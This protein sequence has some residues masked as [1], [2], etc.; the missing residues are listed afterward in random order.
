MALFAL[1]RNCIVLFALFSW[2]KIN[3]R[4]K[5]SKEHWTRGQPVLE[6]QVEKQCGARLFRALYR[7]RYNLTSR[8][9]PPKNARQDGKPIR[10]ILSRTLACL[11]R[12]VTCSQPLAKHLANCCKRKY[13]FSSLV[14]FFFFS[15]KRSCAFDNKLP[16]T[17]GNGR[18][19]EHL[20][21]EHRRT[22]HIIRNT[23]KATKQQKES[24]PLSSPSHCQSGQTE[25]LLVQYG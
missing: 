22:D 16:K 24:K 1:L 12:K 19:A 8:V 21:L 10:Q 5:R 13:K 3:G 17:H 25:H 20:N 2:K 7:I 23:N 9:T 4:R 15:Y 6:H 18:K 14:I 11:S